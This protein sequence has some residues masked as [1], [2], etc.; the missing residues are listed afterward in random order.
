M[1]FGPPHGSE[2]AELPHSALEAV[3][4][5]SRL[6]ESELG[7][8]AALFEALR[9]ESSPGLHR[10]ALFPLVSYQLLAAVQFLHDHDVLQTFT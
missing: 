2:R 5:A 9:R 7:E 4:A 6:S 3:Q 8:S 1:R 10:P